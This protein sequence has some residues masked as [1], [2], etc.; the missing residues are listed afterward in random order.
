MSNRDRCIE[1]LDSFEDSQLEN[2]FSM[3][4]AT[5]NAIDNASDDAFSEALY[6]EYLDCEDPDKHQI[7]G[8]EQLAAQLGIQL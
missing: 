6:K 2:V 8:I 1:L 4:K 5:K 3:L 7:V